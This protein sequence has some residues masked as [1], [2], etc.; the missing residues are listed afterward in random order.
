MK[1][2]ILIIITIFFLSSC[3]P[4]PEEI[5]LYVNQTLEALPS[6]TSFPTNTPFPTNT[7]YPT[8][9]PVNTNTP[10]FKLV[11]AT[12][13]ATPKLS[14]TITNTPTVTLTNTATLD[15]L[16]QS[17]R[18]GFYLIGVDIAPGVWRS[19]GSQDDCYWAVTRADG[20]IIDNHFGM[21]GGTAFLPSSGFQVQFED[22][23]TWTW[24]SN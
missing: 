22:C 1:N 16:K 6:Q 19:D 23:G 14:P 15:P 20:D 5:A 24:L 21:A 12:F 18:D 3:N 4:K 13:T 17:H 10:V 11:T 9:T 8:F 7:A 2:A